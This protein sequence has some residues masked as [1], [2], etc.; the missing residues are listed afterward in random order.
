[1]LRRSKFR[2][3]METL[4]HTLTNG[5]NFYVHGDAAC[6]LTNKGAM[7]ADERAFTVAMNSLQVSVEQSFGLV[8]RSDVA[9]PG[10][11]LVSRM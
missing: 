5:K 7:R 10:K 3:R 4:S 11:L 1:M 6:P 2:E 8:E 9:M